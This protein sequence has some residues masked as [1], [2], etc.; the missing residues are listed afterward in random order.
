MM[1]NIFLR[2]FLTNIYY[3]IFRQKK[4]LNKYE[5]SIE[6][7]IVLNLYLITSSFNI[8][9]NVLIY[10]SERRNLAS[11]FRRY[12]SVFSSHGSRRDIE[13]CLS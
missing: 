12:Y 13:R 8:L 11:I 3:E 9:F 1:Y 10:F 6:N 5:D 7:I 4:Y 2:I